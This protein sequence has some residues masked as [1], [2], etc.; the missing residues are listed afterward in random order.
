MN[1]LKRAATVPESA[2]LTAYRGISSISAYDMPGQGP[3]KEN[4]MTMGLT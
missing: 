3:Q 1:E 2:K 4:T